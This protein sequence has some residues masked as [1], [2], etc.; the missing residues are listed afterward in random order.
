M[1]SDHHT[2]KYFLLLHCFENLQGDTDSGRDQ[3]P[4]AARAL[5]QGTAELHERDVARPS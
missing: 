1:P 4:Q 2:V 3:D 5:F